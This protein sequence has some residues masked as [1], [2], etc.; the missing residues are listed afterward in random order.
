MVRSGKGEAM[1]SKT[2][3]GSCHCGNVRFEADIDLAGGT[4]RCNCSFCSKARAWFVTVPPERVRLLAGGDSQT[5]YRW[6]APGR[7]ESHLTF[8]FCKRCGVR[9][10]GLGE[11]RFRFVNVATLDVDLDELAAAPLRYVD[12]RN[13][14]YEQ[15]P[16]DTRLL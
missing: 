10:F 5:Q 12:G 6:A 9:T 7:S 14:R 16:K 13:D 4:I 1:A 3:R 15:P 8:Q 2:Y 11:D